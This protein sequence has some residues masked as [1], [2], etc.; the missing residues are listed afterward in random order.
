MISACVKSKERRKNDERMIMT[1]EEK[2][3][4]REKNNRKKNK[5]KKSNR[6]GCI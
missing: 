4:N 3:I 2:E 5:N 1:V 6:V